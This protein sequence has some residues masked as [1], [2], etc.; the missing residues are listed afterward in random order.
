MLSKSLTLC[1]REVVMKWPWS[2]CKKLPQLQ[3]S[4]RS[5]ARYHKAWNGDQ[6]SRWPGYTQANRIT[7]NPVAQ[8]PFQMVK[9]G[10]NRQAVPYNTCLRQHVGRVLLDLESLSNRPYSWKG[11][12]ARMP[13][14]CDTY[15]K[16]NQ[17]I[18]GR[19]PSLIG[20]HPFIH[21]FLPS[22]LH[23][24]VRSFIHSV[25]PSFNH[26]FVHSFI[27]SFVRSFI[28]SIIHPFVR[29]FI[30]SVFP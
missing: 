13:R 28:H 7:I 19:V 21:S 11:G 16:L 8:C 12:I 10:R 22:F 27:H 26:S 6:V 15:K 17:Y 14:K 3:S 18:S 25:L 9:S 29:S 1:G 23:S 24:F 2:C 20:S 30:H 5:Y 4:D